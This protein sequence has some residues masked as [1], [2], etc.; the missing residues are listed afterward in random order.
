MSK[1]V[2]VPKVVMKSVGGAMVPMYPIGALALRVN[3]DVLTIR[4]WEHLGIIPQPMFRDTPT[5]K[6]KG[7]RLYTREEID[8]IVSAAQECGIK[9]RESIANTRFAE[10]VAKKITELH[11]RYGAMQ[12]HE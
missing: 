2:R 12:K 10:S 3:R 6:Q 4:R 5:C 7:R 11:V 9:P 8:A 1:P